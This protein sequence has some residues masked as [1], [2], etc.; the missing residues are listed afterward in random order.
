[1]LGLSRGR[2]RFLIAILPLE[3]SLY[4]LEKFAISVG[5]V[6]KNYFKVTF[7]NMNHRFFDFIKLHYRLVQR[8]KLS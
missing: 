5:Q 8:H 3:S 4:R 7:D 2:K 6:A 1:M